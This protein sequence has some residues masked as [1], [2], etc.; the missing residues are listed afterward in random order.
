MPGPEWPAGGLSPAML[1]CVASS[2]NT[3][4]EKAVMGSLP[5]LHRAFRPL[6]RPCTHVRSSSPVNRCA[7]LRSRYSAHCSSIEAVDWGSVFESEARDAPEHRVDDLGLHVRRR[8]SSAAAGS[9]TVQSGMTTAEPD[10]R[11]HVLWLIKGLGPGGAEHLLVSLA[12]VA[13]ATRFRFTAGYVL[14]WK[15]HLVPM[16]EDVGVETISFGVSNALDLRWAWR[17]RKY[18][19]EHDVD[20]IHV[21]SP[22]VAGIARLVRLTLR[23]RPPMIS[24]EHNSWGSHSILTRW[25]NRLTFRLDEFHIAV[26][27][28]VV[29]SMPRGLRSMTE[30]IVHGVDVAGIDS[31]RPERDTVRAELGLGPDTVAV[32]T[33]ANLRWQK[34]YPDLLE[35]ARIV[36]AEGFDVVFFA[37][38]QGPLEEEIRRLRDE[39]GLTDRFRL[40]GYRSDVHRL[41]AGMDVF[42]MASHY[43]G[44]PI[45]VMEA[46]VAGLPVV[47]TDAGSMAEAVENGVD[48]YVVPIGEPAEL[49]AALRELVSDSDRR[50]RMGV[51][52]RAKGT[53]FGIQPAVERTEAIYETVVTR[54]PP[55]SPDHPSTR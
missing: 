32:C 39:L 50:R 24:T 41:L 35:A 25:F 9:S 5:T 7:T 31:Y 3:R 38:G 18:L 2:N 16:I 46:M 48:G 29:E 42:A 55:Q 34:A 6:D 30:T 23:R 45:A 12:R 1:V 52:A 10:E 20:V 13:D 4:V 44:Y 43:E 53:Q 19:A 27:D 51:A 49:A 37:A 11:I 40:L 26:S 47:A 33:V 21:H 54:R 8:Y 36:I 14:D 15:D 17:L 28:P 22:L